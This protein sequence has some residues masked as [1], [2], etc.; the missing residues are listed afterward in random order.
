M[1]PEQAFEFAVALGEFS[2]SL[3]DTKQRAKW[4][5]DMKKLVDENKKAARLIGSPRE[6]ERNLADA[7]RAK[8]AAKSVLQEAEQEA[9]KLLADTN[10][11]LDAREKSL[12]QRRDELNEKSDKLQSERAAFEEKSRKRRE[13][14]NKSQVAI[15]SQNEELQARLKTV[16]QRE[17][18]IGKKESAAA[19]IQHEADRVLAGMKAVVAGG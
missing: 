18:A 19:A 6:I 4:L 7:E 16:A 8:D 1:N 9:E 12:D 3:G 17:E 11:L 10:S 15:D 2:K 13:T 5:A 14:L